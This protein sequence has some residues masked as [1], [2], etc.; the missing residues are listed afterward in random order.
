MFQITNIV[1][2]YIFYLLVPVIG[3]ASTTSETSVPS[4]STGIRGTSELSSYYASFTTSA[5]PVIQ[6][7]PRD[8]RLFDYMVA[9]GSDNERIGLR[10]DIL[11][12]DVWLPAADKFQA[13]S[14]SY[15]SLTTT[16]DQ[17]TSFS[18]DSET[19]ST[20]QS[21][22]GASSA[23]STLIT[24]TTTA[25]ASTSSSTTYTTYNLVEAVFVE[26]CASLGTFN[27]LNSATSHFLNIYSNLLVSAKNATTYFKSFIDGTLLSGVWG[28]DDFKLPFRD[29]NGT[30]IVEFFDFPFVY[31]NF[32]NVGVGALAVGASQSDYGYEFNFLSNFVEN[33]LINSNSY[34]LGLNSYNGT[35][36]Q[37][38][39]GGVNPNLIHHDET[40]EQLMALF[41]FI[42]VYD[43]SGTFVTDNDGLT[44]SIP[45]IPIFGW[46][47]T[48]KS[49]NESIVFANTYDDRTQIASYP[50]PAILDTRYY[51]NYIPYSTLIEIAIELNAVY[52]TDTDRWLVDCSVGETGTID[53]LVG[54]YTIQIPISDVLY[55]AYFN[56]TDLVFE[57]NHS[58]C[59]LAFLP[60]FKL[61]FSLLGTALLK[62]IYL[63]VDNEN[64]KI[65]ISQVQNKLKDLDMDIIDAT[66]T[67]YATV[68][69]Q[70]DSDA[71][72]TDVIDSLTNR[73]YDHHRTVGNLTAGVSTLK[74]SSSMFPGITQTITTESTTYETVFTPSAHPFTGDS[75]HKEN[76]YNI[77]SG[78]IPF[79]TSYTSVPPLTLTVPKSLVFTDTI[80]H[81][82]QV[83]VSDG[84]VLSHTDRG[85]T[86]TADPNSSRIQ[87]TETASTIYG[88]TSL[89]S[90]AKPSKTVAAA[91]NLRVPPIFHCD[92]GSFTYIKLC[93]YV[94]VFVVASVFVL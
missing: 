84:E 58:A 33:D 7:F 20:A 92:N 26:S 69:P 63:A 4:T 32:S 80:R 40:T 28:V 91:S 54:G 57:S 62:N 78:T 46:G 37:L 22:S 50:K 1:L 66:L 87:S 19:T 83:F 5:L 34:S 41:D 44:D 75:S 6:L 64:K 2:T 79:A 76:F 70:F 55:P 16:V 38:I 10:L 13:C 53:L 23:I 56:N 59:Y 77:E 82:S 30:K 67:N 52:L 42:P 93:G 39:L 35:Y 14:A 18:V 65:A 15:S 21:S 27:I 25:S 11:Q 49:T 29:G 88:F 17:W 31:A 60:D 72:A 90:I 48:S 68:T 8:D 81:S 86:A 71:A 89:V 85:G 45:T 61:G 74:T 9:V 36:S 51:F 24:T 12:G 3:D 73:T 43:E 94:F 47:V